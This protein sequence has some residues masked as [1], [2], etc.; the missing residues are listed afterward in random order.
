MDANFVDALAVIEL[1]KLEMMISQNKKTSK[2]IQGIIK[3]MIII[4]M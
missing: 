1:I 3:T 4:M 2:D